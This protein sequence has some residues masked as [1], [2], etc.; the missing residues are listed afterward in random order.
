MED[1]FNIKQWTSKAILTEDI[2]SDEAAEK[3]PA[4]NKSLNQKLSK[5]D[6]IVKDY[7]RLRDLMKT[8]LD[9]YKNFESPKNRELA[10][11]RLKVLTP[12]FQAAKKSYEKLKGVKL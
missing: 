11:N 9:M 4:G 8:E 2:D 10:K 7:K 3:A 1:N 6:K 5:A 12:E